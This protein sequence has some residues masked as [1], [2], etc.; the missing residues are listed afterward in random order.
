MN[1]IFIVSMIE[2]VS[3]LKR[4]FFSVRLDAKA[5]VPLS[6]LNIEFF[7]ARLDVEIIESLKPLI[8]VLASDPAMLRVLL[9]L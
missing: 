4:E 6:D 2:S 7:S 8:Q 3:I 5:K 9:R 1:I